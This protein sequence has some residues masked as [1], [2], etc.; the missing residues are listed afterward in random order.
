MIRR[1]PRSTRTYTLFPDTTLFRSGCA[2]EKRGGPRHHQPGQRHTDPRSG[3]GPLLQRTK[4]SRPVHSRTPS[5][6]LSA[7]RQEGRFAPD[8]VR[9]GT[10]WP[11][12]T[13]RVDQRFA[14]RR[15]YFPLDDRKS[16]VSGKSVSVRL[17]LGGRRINE[18][19]NN[20]K[21]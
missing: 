3:R 1:P 12:S 5:R 7:R 6:N 17:S 16:V 20:T 19:K 11:R 15:K 21:I 14:Q 10:A 13:G 2:A 8:S 4:L 9:E 18:K